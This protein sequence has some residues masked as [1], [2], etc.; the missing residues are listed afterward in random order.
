MSITKKSQVAIHICEHLG[1]FV[2]SV[3]GVDKDRT[4]ESIGRL[5]DVKKTGRRF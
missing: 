5:R 1:T 2:Q 3:F 4:E